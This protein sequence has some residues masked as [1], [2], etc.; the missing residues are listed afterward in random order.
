M[1]LL[2]GFTLKAETHCKTHMFLTFSPWNVQRISRSIGMM[3]LD[4]TENAFML[5]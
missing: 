1:A 5:I 4:M 2:S 3:V